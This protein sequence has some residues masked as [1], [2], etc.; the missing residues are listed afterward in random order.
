MLC[1]VK[2]L[3]LQLD[4]ACTNA[5]SAELDLAGMASDR[6][7]IQRLEA[8]VNHIKNKIKVGKILSKS[9]EETVRPMCLERGAFETQVFAS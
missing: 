9:Y 5:K 8:I 1:Q 7:P 6:I 2:V 4:K 3:S